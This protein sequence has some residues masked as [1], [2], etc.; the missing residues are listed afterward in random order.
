MCVYVTLDHIQQNTT[1]Q[2]L[3]TKTNV[4]FL[5]SKDQ[6]TTKSKLQIRSNSYHPR[7]SHHTFNIT[8]QELI[9][10]ATLLLDGRVIIQIQ[11]QSLT[12]I[13]SKPTALNRHEWDLSVPVTVLNLETNL[14]ACMFHTHLP[15]IHLETNLNYFQS[16][17]SYRAVSTLQPDYI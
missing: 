2:S 3:T 13:Q 14:L 11:V 5:V 7:T 8:A 15:C 12:S 9:Y 6:F 16:V 10:L 17:S 1:I 4:F